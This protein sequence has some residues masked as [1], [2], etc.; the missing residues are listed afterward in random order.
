M[1]FSIGN[2]KIGRNTLIFNLGSA[3]RCPSKKLGLCQLCD[4]KKCYALKAEKMY[5][6][7]LPYR[8]RQERDWKKQSAADIASDLSRHS[9]RNTQYIRFNE[10]GDFWDQDCIEKLKTIARLLPEYCFYG[11]TARKDLSFKR[12]PKNL[13]I[14][15][16]N[17]KRGNMNSFMAVAEYSGNNPICAGDCRICGLC[18]KAR[19]L[20]IEC[21]MH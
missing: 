10:S 5:P 6:P 18:K 3:K 8:N 2:K 13:C 20:T 1:K 19:N 17:W 7:V 15:G 12:L 14:N 21:K 16:S 9:T 11:Y 4:P